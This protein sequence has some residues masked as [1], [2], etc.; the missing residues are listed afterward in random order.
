M[1]SLHAQLFHIIVYPHGV[2]EPPSS[3]RAD[4]LYLPEVGRLGIAWNSDAT[5]ADVDDGESG[6]EMWINERETWEQWN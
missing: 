2:D 4:A 3:E 1:G 6:I 5:W